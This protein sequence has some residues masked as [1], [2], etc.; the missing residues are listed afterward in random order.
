MARGDSCT[1]LMNFVLQHPTVIV[2]KEDLEKFAFCSAFFEQS[3]THNYVCILLDGK[4]VRLHRAIMDFPSCDVD[5][6]DRNVLNNSKSNL[7]LANRTQ[8]NANKPLTQ[9]NSSGYKGVSWCQSK[10]KWQ[11][12]LKFKGKNKNLGYFSDPVFAALAYDMAAEQF[13]GEFACTNRS[14]GLF[15]KE[16]QT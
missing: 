3:A 6:V 16:N 10:G 13:F 7:R 2:D 4:K 12:Q 1:T 14:L 5:H 15:C 11:A 8:N 9:A